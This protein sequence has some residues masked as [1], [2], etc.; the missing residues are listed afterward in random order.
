MVSVP[1]MSVTVT[2]ASAQVSQLAVEPKLIDPAPDP[3]TVRSTGRAVVV[4]LEYRKLSVWLPADS[5]DTD[6]ST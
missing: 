6:H 4:P 3:L 1:A 5:P 2:V